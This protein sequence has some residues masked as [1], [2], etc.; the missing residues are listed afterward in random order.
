MHSDMVNFKP[1]TLANTGLYHPD[2]YDNH[3]YNGIPKDELKLYEGISDQNETV[4]DFVN[5]PGDNPGTITV[6]DEPGAN[7]E[8]SDWKNYIASSHCNN[9]GMLPFYTGTL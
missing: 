7:E 3:P 2:K 8:P 6:I 5:A 4:L 1:G 9:P